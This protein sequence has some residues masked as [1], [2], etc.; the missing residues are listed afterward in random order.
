[1][2]I[3][4]EDRFKEEKMEEQSKKPYA[5]PELTVHGTV[6]QITKALEE[7]AEDFTEGGTQLE[8]PEPD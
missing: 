1:M 7:G 4:G 5:T 2:H 3:E 8:E 6:E